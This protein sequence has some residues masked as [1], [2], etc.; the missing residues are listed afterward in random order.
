MSDTRS[1]RPR[2]AGVSYRIRAL[3]WYRIVIPRIIHQ[4]HSEQKFSKEVHS[5]IELLRSNNPNWEHRFYDEF[6]RFSFIRQ[7]YDLRILRAYNKINP[8]YGAA[9]ADFFRYLLM[10]KTGGLYLDLKSNSSKPLDE[11]VSNHN[12]ILSH[13]DNRPE[14]ETPGWGLFEGGPEF[15]EYQQ[16]HIACTAGHPFLEQVILAVLYK[17]ETY[18]TAFGPTGI[19]GVTS[20]TGP[21]VYTQAIMGIQNKMD[22]HWSRNNKELGLIYNNLSTNHRETL[23]KES[24]PH[25]STLDDP[26]IL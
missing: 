16:W 7:H 21:V 2:L 11:V 23:Y 20:T 3:T 17:I 5:N 1:S 18:D 15:G 8:I 22:F 25:Y 19:L 24:R 13:W 26:L 12:Y 6:D 14:G 4:T 10:Y 9:R